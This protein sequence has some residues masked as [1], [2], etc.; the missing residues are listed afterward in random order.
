M[1]ETQ[2]QT[3][4]AAA[5]DPH[6]DDD[7]F[8]ILSRALQG[9]DPLT[10]GPPQPNPVPIRTPDVPVVPIDLSDY[11]LP[12]QSTDFVDAAHGLHGHD[13][14]D[15]D[16]Y[17]AYTRGAYRHDEL[18]HV[19]AWLSAVYRASTAQDDVDE[20][21][22]VVEVQAPA[23]EADGVDLAVP[24]TAAPA[25]VAGQRAR[26][27]PAVPGS[28]TTSAADAARRASGTFTPGSGTSGTPGPRGG[29]SPGSIGGVAPPAPE[30]APEAGP[31]RSRS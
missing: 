14:P 8:T 1:D 24:P 9:R 29:T 11:R 5:A 3:L 10:G 22:D 17:V 25:P 28:S 15:A 26:T 20:I 13:G 21:D 27:S 31:G 18:P 12:G 16:G 30:Q 6:V 2:E 4:R 23:V 7:M 19:I